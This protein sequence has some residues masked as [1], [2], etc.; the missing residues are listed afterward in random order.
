MLSRMLPAE[1]GLA[2]LAPVLVGGR[3]HLRRHQ[4]HRS[5]HPPD[6]L[7][8]HEF[9]AGGKGVLLGGYTFDG[10]NSYEFTA[11]PPAER[12]RSARL[13]LVA[14]IHP[15]YPAE[16]E[17]GV[18]VAWSRVPFTL[19]CAGDWSDEARKRITTISVR[20]TGGSFS[21]ASTPLTFRP[22]RRARSSPRWTRS[23]ACTSGLSGREAHCG[24]WRSGSS[25]RRR[26]ACRRW[27]MTAA[28]KNAGM[29]H[30]WEFSEQGGGA[31]WSPR[32]A[33]W[34]SAGRGRRGRP[35]RGSAAGGGQGPRFHRFRPRCAS[36]CKGMPPFAT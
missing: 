36:C 6:L 27:P 17:N 23:S 20:S 1:F 15:E 16:F 34:S 13:R 28:A 12:V 4:L 10:A 31:D 8:K 35:G 22:G 33:A 21:L 5:A 14:E 24:F 9:N 18:S 2:V 32:R 3:A 7:P 25:F 30:G 26:C 19:G 11:L 29:S